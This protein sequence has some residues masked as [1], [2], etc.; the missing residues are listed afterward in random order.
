MTR[1]PL[2]AIKRDFQNDLRFHKDDLTELLRGELRKI[3]VSSRTS[4]GETRVRLA[5]IQIPIA[6]TNRKG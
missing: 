3:R 1:T 2:D 4:V 6:V 5:D